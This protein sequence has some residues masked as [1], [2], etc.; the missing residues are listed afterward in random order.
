VSCQSPSRLSV[1]WCLHFSSFVVVCVIV[2]AEFLCRDVCEKFLFILDLFLC[3]P[4]HG[5]EDGLVFL[6]GQSCWHSVFCADAIVFGLCVAR[7]GTLADPLSRQCLLTPTSATQPLPTSYCVQWPSTVA[8]TTTLPR[9]DRFYLSHPPPFPS[10]NLSP[11]L[12][13]GTTAGV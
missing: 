8:P 13:T 11:E 12:H 7:A 1:V 9:G 4:P 6:L 3:L 5:L 10:S 2:T